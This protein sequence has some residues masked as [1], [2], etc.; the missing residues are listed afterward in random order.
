MKLRLPTKKFD[1]EPQLIQ[2]LFDHNKAYY[3]NIVFREAAYGDVE[4]RLTRFEKCVDPQDGINDEIYSFIWDEVVT[5]Y[6]WDEYIK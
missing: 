4:S 1:N 5:N 6:E 2:W 3:S